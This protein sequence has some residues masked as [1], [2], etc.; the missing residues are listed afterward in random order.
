M[1][2]I[3]NGNAQILVTDWTS[4]TVFSANLY[5]SAGGGGILA[6]PMW[7]QLKDGG[8]TTVTCGIST[9]G[10]NFVTV[11]TITKSTGF[12]GATGYA[13]VIFAVYG[14]AKA[15][16]GTLMSYTQA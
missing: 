15:S 13:N 8:G 4:P 1:T 2:L 14:G 12:L 7:L 16:M 10:Y 3:Y 11:A 6:S 5:T 9:D